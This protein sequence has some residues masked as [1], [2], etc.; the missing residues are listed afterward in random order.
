MFKQFRKDSVVLADLNKLTSAEN[1]IEV[2]GN[3]IY[4]DFTGSAE[5]I[6]STDP[7]N[8]V[9]YNELA[10]LMGL[11]IKNYCKKDYANDPSILMQQTDVLLNEYHN[12]LFFNYLP[13]VDP[14][15]SLFEAFESGPLF[16]EAFFYS[17]TAGYD[18]QYIKI[19]VQKYN[20]DADWLLSNKGIILAE[21]P[22]FFLNIIR[23][24]NTR[25]ALNRSSRNHITAKD[26]VGSFTLS[27]KELAAGL[28]SG[29]AIINALTLLL[30]GSQ[31]QSYNDIADFNLFVEKPIIRLGEDAYFIASPYHVGEALYE[32]P[33][34]WM[35]AD[36]AYRAIAAAN[37]GKA[38][39]N[40][41]Y[42]NVVKLFGHENVF[43]NVNIKAS[44]AKTVTDIDVIAYGEESAII[45]QIKSKKLTLLSRK[46]DLDAIKSDFKS[47]VR[48]AKTQADQCIE[49]LNH[50]DNYV[51]EM[52]GIESFPNKAV[53][54]YETAI[55]L[56]DQY[57]AISHQ[58]HIL[59]GDELKTT[60][61]AFSIFD[62]ETLIQFLKMPTSFLDYIRRRTLYSKQYRGANELQYLAQYLDRGLQEPEENEFIYIDPQYG[63][64]MDSVQHQNNIAEIKSYPK[65]KS[66]RNDPCPC[67]S[68]KKFKKCHG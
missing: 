7:Q 32:A 53:E 11:W 64:L 46:G 13:E 40:L 12:S 27:K 24:V 48:V 62:L 63:Q 57:P 25:L 42:K 17:S 26:K 45:F 61:I 8:V 50:P 43:R 56:L 22:K 54:R 4:R 34:Y 47:A 10:L 29:E 65:V 31:N 66:G 28:K 30:D 49:A 51:F 3:I 21:L 44:R 68:G 14:G 5:K 33:Y 16:K 39:E 1:Y 58:T 55:V 2:I 15:K 35:Y 59:F 19:L 37:R 9:S 60:P 52:E 67:G 41:V 36:D 20:D 6:S 23:T 18:R 38:A